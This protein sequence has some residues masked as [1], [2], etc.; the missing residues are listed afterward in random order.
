MTRIIRPSNGRGG[1]GALMARVGVRLEKF[2]AGRKDLAI[3]ICGRADLSAYGIATIGERLTMGAGG[4]AWASFALRSS[5]LHPLEA[6]SEM[7]LGVRNGL[8][9]DRADPFG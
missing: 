4:A 5:G 3:P 7:R 9:A 2:I 8:A 1:V 6:L